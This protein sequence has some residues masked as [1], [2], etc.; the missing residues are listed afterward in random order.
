MKILK[1]CPCCNSTKYRCDI[2]QS[3]CKVIYKCERCGFVNIR[4][5]SWDDIKELVK[6]KEDKA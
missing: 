4:I 5:M 6:Q 1:K 3:T 2:N